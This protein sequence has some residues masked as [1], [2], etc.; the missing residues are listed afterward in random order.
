ME[1][2]E[3][4]VND[5]FLK[6]GNNYKIYLWEPEQTLLVKLPK[7]KEVK[8]INITLPFPIHIK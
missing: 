2:L 7:E 5:N 3:E 8:V 4:R 1:D 6:Q